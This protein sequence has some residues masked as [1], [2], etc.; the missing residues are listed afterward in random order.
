M[1]F[2]VLGR[3]PRKYGASR[4]RQQRPTSSRSRPELVNQVSGRAEVTV[5]SD[6][7]LLLLAARLNLREEHLEEVVLEAP[8]GKR[9]RSVGSCSP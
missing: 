5:Q 3:K 8:V 9:R 4:C 7:R 1:A 6:V 2:Q